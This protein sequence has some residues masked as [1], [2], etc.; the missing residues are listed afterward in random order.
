MQ[1]DPTDAASVEAAT[2]DQLSRTYRSQSEA[3]VEAAGVP[4]A[5]VAPKVGRLRTFTLR[6]EMADGSV[7]EGAFTNQI[8]TIQQ[9]IGVG[10]LRARLTSGVAYELLDPATVN[11]TEMVAQL[12]ISLT[13]RPDWAKDLLGMD[14]VDLIGK[15]YR[16][17][18][19]HEA[20]FRRPNADR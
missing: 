2:R 4:A 3:I 14:D 13:D 16:E 6:H 20:M 7:L 19:A 8:L 9:Q 17:V 10:V 12:S 11:L 15:I 1:H 18:A 5:K